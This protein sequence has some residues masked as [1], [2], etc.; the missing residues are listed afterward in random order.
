MIDDY[1]AATDEVVLAGCQAGE[2]EAIAVLMARHGILAEL[3]MLRERAGMNP[4]ELSMLLLARLSEHPERFGDFSPSQST[5][6]AFLAVI[7]R[8]HAEKARAPLVA[9]SPTPG[10]LDVVAAREAISSERLAQAAKETIARQPPNVT[11]I[12][13][14]RLHG[15]GS[16]HI[17]ALVG[18]SEAQ[19]VSALEWVAQRLGALESEHAFE[20]LGEYDDLTLAFRVLLQASPPSERVRFARRTESERPLAKLRAQV[21]AVM[22]SLKSE[23]LT[24]PPPG[25]GC[26]RPS[27]IAGYVD[28]ST[29]GA[30]RARAESHVSGC[31]AC[32]D[33]IAALSCDLRALP[34]VRDVLSADRGAQLAAMAI[35]IACFDAGTQLA[36]A[37][38]GRRDNRS[39]R[40]AA[41]LARLGRACRALEGG[42]G[43]G[44]E[45]EMSGL[46]SRDVPSDDEAPVV[47]FEALAL[48]DSG[49]AFRAIDETNA[50]SPV[51]ARVRVL[52]A[53]AG[54][55]APLG[56]AWARA[57]K[58]G[59][60]VDPGAVEDAE[61]VL[62]I[63]EGVALP[64]EI[65][66]ERLRALVP[67][68][69]RVVLA[70]H[71][72]PTR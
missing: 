38:A 19:V 66:V 13:R 61:C 57:V 48:G 63:G 34:L 53:A 12:L 29:R 65:I 41:D 45:R 43:S 52:A 23:L 10:P 25:A 39:A 22:R 1:A 46:V 28:G 24:T 20:H 64:R 6:R 72:R 17:A 69:V 60:D 56:H 14:M 50:R 51:A 58:D 42:T 32:L 62:S 40:M 59:Y 8:R 5:L 33:E 49:S 26:L 31:A 9:P 47:A 2:P 3:G 16:A 21:D 54:G 36:D 18:T 37:V 67:D 27:Q 68:L 7:S 4:R 30:A 35:G 55:D 44:Q 70:L 71:A 15:L 11:A